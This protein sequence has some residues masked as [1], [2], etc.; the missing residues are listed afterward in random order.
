MSATTSSQLP[1]Q[2]FSESRLERITSHLQSYVDKGYL[3]G[4]NAAITRNSDLVY[5][6]SFGKLG[7]GKAKMEQDAVF[8]IYS[9]TKTITSVAALML[10][11][12]GKFL[13]TDPVH[14]YLPAFKSTKVFD[15]STHTGIKLVDQTT[16][17]TIQHLFTHTA[18]LSYGWYHDTP[19]DEMY[20]ILSQEVDPFTSKLGDFVN[21]LASVPLVYQ[22]G[23]HWRYSY[24]TDVL[25][26]LVEV[27][28][29]E[30]LDS[31]FQSR[32]FKPL[33]MND[34]GFSVKAKQM[35][36]YTSVY[37]PSE[38]YGFGIDYSTIPFGGKTYPIDTPEKS[39]F[40]RP[41]PLLK[42]FSGGGGLVS[43]LPDY[44]TFAQML[45]NKGEFFG[46]RL[47]SRKTVELMS[48]NHVPKHIR[49]LEIGGT[50][51]LGEGFG[52]GVSVIENPEQ[53]TLLGSTGNYG[54][55]G[56][57]MTN[58]WV[59]PIENIVGV[60]MTQFMPSDYYPIAQEFRNLSYQALVD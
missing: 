38:Q 4:I 35:D 23:S 59:D 14:K 5:N 32:I 27:I 11:E 15:S 30:S 41:R 29:G 6:H 54:W 50:P 55:G 57:A 16:E 51:L 12:E 2:G 39:M 18:G 28:S 8:R 24:A 37:C 49:P 7:E 47:L 58:Y 9:M 45:C 56:A 17:M 46:E 43:T 36:R 26:H 22:P 44:M 25:G 20:R 1:L 42:G 40:V 31:F 33:G 34:T 48:M 10:L 52:L 19:V 3:K 53:N 13:L 21:A 60:I